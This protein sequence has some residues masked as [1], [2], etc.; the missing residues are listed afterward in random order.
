M[1]ISARAATSENIAIEKVS[2]NIMK[3]KVTQTPELKVWQFLW[4]ELGGRVAE[5]LAVLTRLEVFLS[6]F[7]TF[8]SVDQVK[9][10]LST[11]RG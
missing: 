9:P 1:W 7:E 5:W 4:V 10:V 11:G 8:T 2:S 3:I 6:D